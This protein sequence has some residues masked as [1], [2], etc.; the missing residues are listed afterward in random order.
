MTAVSEPA[1]V[2]VADY[3][4]AAWL[5]LGNLQH[6]GHTLY[7]CSLPGLAGF[8]RYRPRRSKPSTPRRRT[9]SLPRHQRPV[10]FCSD[11][12]IVAL[13][14]TTQQCDPK[15]IKTDKP[16]MMCNLQGHGF[17]VNEVAERVGFEPTMAFS[18]HTRFPSER[19]KPDYATSPYASIILR[20]RLYYSFSDILDPRGSTQIR[21]AP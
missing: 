20:R 7:R 3:P 5:R 14:K 2:S 6:P 11:N 10:Y 13:V 4:T 12:I 21:S 17:V 9:P 19:T 8:Q 18:H 16:R 1:L 15:Q